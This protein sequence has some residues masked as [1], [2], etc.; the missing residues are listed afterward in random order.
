MSSAFLS[1]NTGQKERDIVLLAQLDTSIARISKLD[2][3]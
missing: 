1:R 3:L 2:D